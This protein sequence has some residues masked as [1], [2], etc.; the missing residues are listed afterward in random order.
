MPTRI[1]R[2]KTNDPRAWAKWYMSGAIGGKQSAGAWKMLRLEEEKIQKGLNDGYPRSVC[3]ALGAGEPGCPFGKHGKT[4]RKLASYSYKYLLQ[5]IEGGDSSKLDAEYA[6]KLA[7]KYGFDKRLLAS[8][9][10]KAAP[11][12]YEK[13]LESISKGLDYEGDGKTLEEM[14]ADARALA[15]KSGL[16]ASKVETALKQG[17]P[18]RLAFVIDCYKEMPTRKQSD[19]IRELMRKYNIEPEG[20]LDKLLVR[21]LQIDLAIRNM[22]FPSGKIMR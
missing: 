8:A 17:A 12:A 4:I 5:E 1:N 13:L 7:G 22:D 16:D 18:K 2:S 10:E 9:I 14:A 3:I 15:T 20:H 6:A 11:M 19:E 21:N